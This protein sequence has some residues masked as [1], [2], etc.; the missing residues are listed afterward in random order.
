MDHM[1]VME[2]Q[3]EEMGEWIEMEEGAHNHNAAEYK[4][5]E[6]H[7]ICEQLQSEKLCRNHHEV[8]CEIQ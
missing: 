7:L 5:S 8:G 3:Q 4:R 1:K 6:A 2:D